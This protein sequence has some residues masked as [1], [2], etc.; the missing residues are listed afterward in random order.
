MAGNCQNVGI[1]H[2]SDLSGFRD[3]LRRWKEVYEQV[4]WSIDRRMGS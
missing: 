3:W 4:S 2:L 1:L